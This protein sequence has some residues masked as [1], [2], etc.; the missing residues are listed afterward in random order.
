MTFRRRIIVAMVPLFALLVALG[1]TGTVLI[2]HLGNRIDEILR[3][4]YDSVIYMRDL[5]ESWNASTPRSS[6]RWP[7]G[8]RNPT[9]STRR[10]GDG[11]T[12]PCP[13]SSTIS[14]CPGKADWSTHLTT[15]SDH[16]RRQGDEFFKRTRPTS[17]TSSTLASR[18]RRGSTADSAR[19]RPFRAKFLRINQDNMED[20]RTGRRAAWPVPRSSGMAAAWPSALPWP[21]SSSPARSARSCYPIRAV[22]E[23]AAAIGAGNLDQLVPVS[24][25]MNWGNWPAPSTPWPASFAITANRTRHN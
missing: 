7:G 3:E 14:P 13:R 1:G 4:N 2:Y 20:G 19:S 8:K 6:S 22:T 15:L 12:P 17:G 5:N 23:S 11:T 10:I 25:T 16:Y 18:T 21:Y 9:S 24:P